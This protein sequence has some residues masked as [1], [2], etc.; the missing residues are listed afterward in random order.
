ME[1]IIEMFELEY[2]D[3]LYSI[4]NKY[5]DD[6]EKEPLDGDEVEKLINHLRNQLNLINGNIT[7]DEYLEREEN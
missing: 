6:W 1:Y 5:A 2:E 4:L 7:T 3:E